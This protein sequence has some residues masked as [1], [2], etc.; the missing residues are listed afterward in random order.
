VKTWTHDDISPKRLWES[1]LCTILQCI[2]Q[3]SLQEYPT[4]Y[5]TGVKYSVYCTPTYIVVYSKYYGSVWKPSMEGVWS[6]EKSAC[7]KNEGGHNSLSTSKIQRGHNIHSFE[8]HIQS[9][10]SYISHGCETS[11]VVRFTNAPRNGCFVLYDIRTHTLRAFRL[12]NREK[13]WHTASIVPSS[14]PSRT[15]RGEGSS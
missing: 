9:R 7:S 5:F 3:C 12:G 1:R 8:K 2:L 4:V 14:G 11:S 6:L 10:T 15:R 13:R